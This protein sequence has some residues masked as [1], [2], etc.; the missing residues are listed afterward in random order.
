MMTVTG[1]LFYDYMVNV[2]DDPNSKTEYETDQTTS[3]IA[4]PSH[5]DHLTA[6]TMDINYDRSDPPKQKDIE[7]T[8]KVTPATTAKTEL[9]IQKTL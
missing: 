1:L 6:T 7:S 9:G 5:I 4:V 8:E 2:E 3:N